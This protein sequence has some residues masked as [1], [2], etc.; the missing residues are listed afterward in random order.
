[1]FLNPTKGDY[2]YNWHPKK[3]SLESITLLS[4]KIRVKQ[5]S[6]ISIL[7]ELKIFY[8]TT[9]N[10]TKTPKKENKIIVSLNVTN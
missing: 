6:K 9:D 10:S 7:S 8:K 3:Y 2:Y 1:M 4:E 5:R